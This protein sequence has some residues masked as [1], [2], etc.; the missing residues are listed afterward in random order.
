V[1][2]LIVGM[3]TLVVE[4]INAV[5]W[6]DPYSS[7]KFLT[8]SETDVR[9]AAYGI[10]DYNI[11]VGGVTTS[12]PNVIAG[13]WDDLNIVYKPLNDGSNAS[14]I[15]CIAY[16]I[17]NNN[18]IV[19]AIKY[20]F[21][22]N[23]FSPCIWYSLV[24]QPNLLNITIAGDNTEYNGGGARSIN[25]T[26][27]IV[28]YLNKFILG[29][30]ITSVTPVYWHTPTSQPVKLQLNEEGTAHFIN[31]NGNIYGRSKNTNKIFKWNSY[32]DE[33]TEITTPPYIYT[34]NNRSNIIAYSNDKSSSTIYYSS[35][36]SVPRTL[37]LTID[38]IVHEEGDAYG[39]TN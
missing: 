28:G 29:S 6:K 1:Y 30:G 19:G 3:L 24:G 20:D 37:S 4:W 11:V 10:N 17:N 15:D 8:M 5:Y 21:N 23:L 12:E 35:P 25:K 2:I 39:L 33:P 27:N 38:G 26:G 31:D 14:V 16:G 9:S 22:S 18:N 32:T 36:T 13:Y 7:P 34:I